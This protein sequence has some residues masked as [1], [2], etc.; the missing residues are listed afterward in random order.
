MWT[1][2]GSTL[3]RGLRWNPYK[4]CGLTN[5]TATDNKISGCVYV[6][7]CQRLYN[8]QM[9][10]FSSSLISHVTMSESAENTKLYTK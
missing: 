3:K 7:P 8:K 5:K 10:H 1:V 6:C 9:V 4:K 2:V